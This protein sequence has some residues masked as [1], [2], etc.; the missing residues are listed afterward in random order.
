[1]SQFL[2]TEQNILDY[3]RVKK[4]IIF[5]DQ[6][7]HKKPSL[8]EI[9]DQVGLSLYHFERLFSKWA[10][11]SPQRFVHFLSKEYLKNLLL[12]SNNLLETTYK[13]GLSSS[14]RLHELFVNYEAMT[15]AQFRERGKGLQIG[16][17]FEET[18]F[19]KCLIGFTKR[20]VCHLVFVDA[21]EQK[22]LAEFKQ[23]WSEANFYEDQKTAFGLIQKIFSFQKTDSDKPL[24]VFVRGTNLQIKVWEALLKIPVGKVASYSE[25]AESIGEPKAVRAVASS[26]GKNSVG[27]LIPCHR[28]IQTTA[29]LGGYRWGLE[30]KQAILGWEAGLVD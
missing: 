7:F 3:D 13:A 18:P 4:A 6:N 19:G 15:P 11:T 28:V 26:C 20:G 29:G 25:I 1:M 22:A 24:S 27:F 10:G 17:G 16:Y 8:K 5:I 9:A 23:N 30:R 2:D 14:S 12:E 21:D